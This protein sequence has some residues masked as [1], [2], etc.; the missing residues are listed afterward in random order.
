MLYTYMSKYMKKIMTEHQMTLSVI[1][2][3]PI[4]PSFQKMTH[5]YFEA[6][7]YSYTD[8]KGIICHILNSG[9]IP[10]TYIYR[11]HVDECL[12]FSM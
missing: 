10:T 2:V 6:S 12:I 7:F 8:P 11:V 5:M 4:L 1:T 3:D 9:T